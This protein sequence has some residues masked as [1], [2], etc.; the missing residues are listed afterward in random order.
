MS[1]ESSPE[2]NM[3]E[4]PDVHGPLHILRTY[5]RVAVVGFS[6]DP[7]RASHAIAAYL[8]AEGY[9]LVL[10]N[11]R[12]A[13]Q[14]LLGQRVY[15][16]LVEAQEAGEHIEIVDVFRKPSELEPILR[17]AIQVGARVL[18]LQLGIRNEEIGRQAIAAGLKF[19]EDRCIKIEHA[20]LLTA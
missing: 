5:K 14:I 13:G 1:G 18:W 16:S 15:A 2:E 17:E 20:Q 4:T 19:V 7:T 9:Q 12:Y 6:A 11:P 10:V 3:L 8:L